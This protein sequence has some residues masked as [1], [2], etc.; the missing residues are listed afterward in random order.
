DAEI[1]EGVERVGSELNSRA[2]FPERGGFFQQDGA[3]SLLRKTER[4][5]EAADAS[6]CDQDRP[7]ARF[8]SHQPDFL[9]C[10]SASSARNGT[11]DA[12]LLRST[13]CVINVS[14][15]RRS[16]GLSGASMRA[17]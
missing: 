14:S 1:I 13:S 4:G 6:A 15:V 3:D 7:R 8:P 16:T 17:W 5:G 10:S 12:S 9:K 2:D 11:R